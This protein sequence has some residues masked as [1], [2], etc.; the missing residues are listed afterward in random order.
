MMLPAL[1]FA[2]SSVAM[3]VSRCS[4]ATV[5]SVTTAAL[6]K[7]VNRPLFLYHAGTYLYAVFPVVCVY[8]NS[9]VNLLQGH[10]MPY[11]FSTYNN[12]Y[13]SQYHHSVWKKTVAVV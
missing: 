1:T 7:P 11:Y 2:R 10:L 5:S 6:R 3:M 8:G 13:P 12:T 9:H 4:F